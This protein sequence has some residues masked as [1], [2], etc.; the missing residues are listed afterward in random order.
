MA[1]GVAM[2]VMGSQNRRGIRKWRDIIDI[3]TMTTV[4]LSKVLVG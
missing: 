3:K 2:V 1:M 4:M